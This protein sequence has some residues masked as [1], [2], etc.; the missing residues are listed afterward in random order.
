MYNQIFTVNNSVGPENIP[1]ITV[2]SS[3]KIKKYDQETGTKYLGR[4]QRVAFVN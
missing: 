2:L 3:S 4:Q 1:N